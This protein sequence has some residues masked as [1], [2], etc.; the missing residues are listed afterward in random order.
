M[1]VLIIKSIVITNKLILIFYNL[2]MS[3]F[4]MCIFHFTNIAKNT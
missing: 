1:M 4:L 2:F 3:I